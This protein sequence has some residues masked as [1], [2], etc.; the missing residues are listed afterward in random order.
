MPRGKTSMEKYERL[1]DSKL[2]IANKRTGEITEAEVFM[3]ILA[4]S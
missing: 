1:N 2:H 4:A 3:A